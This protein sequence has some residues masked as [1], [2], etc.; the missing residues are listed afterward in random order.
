MVDSDGQS[1]EYVLGSENGPEADGVW[2][3]G[4]NEVL[5]YV[6]ER[7]AELDI[8]KGLPSASAAA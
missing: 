1:T 8:G 4:K 5:Q 3:I 2:T 6:R 7:C